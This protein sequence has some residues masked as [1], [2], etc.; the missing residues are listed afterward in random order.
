MNRPQVVNQPTTSQHLAYGI[1]QIADLLAPT[2]GPRGGVVAHRVDTR[3]TEMLDDSS[4]V[5]RRII[6]LGDAQRDIGAMIMRSLIWRVG[7]R[8]GDGG[9]TAAVLARALFNEGLRQITAGANAMQLAQ[10]VRLGVDVA[11]E[12]LKKQSQPITSEDELAHLAYSIAGRRD[13][14]MV[15]GEMA[16]LL[17]PDANV[18]ID[19]LVA[20]YLERR[21]ITGAHFKAQISSMFFYTEPQKKRTLLVSPLIALV[22]QQLTEAEQAVALLE[23]ALQRKAKALAIIAHDITGPALH[24]LVSNNQLPKEKKKLEIFGGKLMVLGEERT[25][26]YSDLAMMTGATLLGPTRTRSAIAAK[27]ED[28]GVTQRVEHSDAGLVIVTPPEARAT[29]R[30]TVNAL[31]FQLS[32]LPFN[33]EERPKLVR[34]LSTLTGGLGELKIGAYNQPERDQLEEYSSRALKVLSSAQKGGVVAGAGAAL[35]HCVPAVNAIQAEGDVAVGVKLLATVLSAPL[36]QI[37]VN[38]GVPSEALYLQQI[39]DA[40]A[41]AS[42]DART[43]EVVNGFS[44]GVLDVTDVT[45]DVLQTAISGALMAL[46]TDAIVYHKNPQQS[47]EP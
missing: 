38:Y 39:A 47:M 19:K 30:E 3:R 8:S 7:Q 34:R 14:A 10:G 11:L 9:A 15:L 4:T 35:L 2:L 37:L 25:Y 16:Y 40:G 18:I 43:G 41:P 42:F 1:N 29:I 33:D 12:E 5:V 45:V 28:L 22:D 26:G 23:A 20:P 24:V 27:P 44:D 6:S 13:L 36:R 17:G 31:R 32:E 21:Y 46:T